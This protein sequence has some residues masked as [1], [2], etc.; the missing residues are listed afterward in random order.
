MAE[1][2]NIK[3]YEEKFL[4]LNLNWGTI[5]TLFGMIKELVTIC[6]RLKLS[7]QNLNRGTICPLVKNMGQI[8]A[9]T[10]L[11]FAGSLSLFGQTIS[12]TVFDKNSNQPIGYVNVGIVGKIGAV[13][14]QNG[15]Y[16]LVIEPEHYN[17]TL[18]FSYIGY[19]PYFVKV[20]DFLTLNNGNVSLE[21]KAF[22]INELIVRPRR[23]RQ[24]RLGISARH[25]VLCFDTTSTG[26]EDGLFIKNE[27]TVVI[28][29]VN[30]RVTSTFDTVVFRMNIYKASED[31]RFE[32]IMNSPV[33]VT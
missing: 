7:A 9:I 32:N 17:D 4:G 24:S 15:R 16:T 21:E 6:N 31:M 14:E 12:G 25:K 2:A 20:S 33:Y 23:T 10:L 29:E 3:L 18:M 8:Y 30:Y 26:F 19:H 22:E 27:N 28:N 11:F 5:C 1:K 13:S